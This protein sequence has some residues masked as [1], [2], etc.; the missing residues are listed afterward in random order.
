MLSLFDICFQP[1]MSA[2]NLI[3]LISL[4]D[5]CLQ[6]N[7]FASNLIC[8]LSL[9]DICFLPNM[10]ASS[11]ICLL[12]LLDVCFRPHVW[13]DLNLS[14]SSFT[15]C[16]SASNLTCLL[17]AKYSIRSQSSKILTQRCTLCRIL[18]TQQFRLGDSIFQT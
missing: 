17:L 6:P 2:S 10:S 1:N 18:R 12:S 5:V 3:C 13:S 8:L 15:Y 4:L 7:M 11:L 16:T 14:T 9:L